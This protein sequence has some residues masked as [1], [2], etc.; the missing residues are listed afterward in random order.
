MALASL[1]IPRTTL[2]HTSARLC[3][4]GNKQRAFAFS[5]ASAPGNSSAVNPAAT[6]SGLQRDARKFEG[7]QKFPRPETIPWQEELANK[8]Q[9]IGFIGGPVE[10]RYTSTG[11]AF[12]STNLAAKLNSKTSEPTWFA[13]KFWHEMAEIAAEHVKTGDKVYVSG[14]M[15]HDATE[16]D[17]NTRTMIKVVVSLLNFVERDPSFGPHTDA[18]MNSSLLGSPQEGINMK[19]AISGSPQ[20]GKNM[21]Q[22]ITGPPQEST[23][24]KQAISGSKVM[25][26]EK[27]WEAFFL[28]PTEWW[29]NRKDKRNPKAPDFKHKTTG[30]SLWIESYGNPSWVKSQLDK[31]DDES[32]KVMGTEKL[33]EAFFLNPTEW[34]DNRKDKRNP[35][36][37]DFKHKTTGESLWIGSYGNPSWVKSQ[38][39]KLDESMSFSHQ[40]TNPKKSLSSF[41]DSDFNLF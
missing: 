39:D 19:H 18:N 11:K 16:D 21:K 4:L 5:F 13:L 29:D 2:S 20:E 38:L 33:W 22:A 10:L 40:Q 23:N 41:G 35:K 25:G 6:F 36:A 27:L 14:Y 32:S 8:V 24:M 9:L 3:L 7:A 26:T 28:N 15:N 12:V 37:P 31:L 34:W 1:V 17:K 30:E